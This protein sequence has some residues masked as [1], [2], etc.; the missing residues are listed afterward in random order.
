MQGTLV[1]NSDI[2]KGMPDKTQALPNASFT[3][4][5]SSQKDQDTLIDSVIKDAPILLAKFLEK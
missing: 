1:L 5:P 4:P 2:D 3:L